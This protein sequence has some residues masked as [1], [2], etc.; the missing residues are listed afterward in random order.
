MF[1]S[2]DVTKKLPLHKESSCSIPGKNM[3][4]KKA[5]DNEIKILPQA[6]ADGRLPIRPHG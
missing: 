4:R 2:G 5:P 1:V 3:T 6:P